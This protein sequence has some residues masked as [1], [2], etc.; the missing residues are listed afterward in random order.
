MA[1]YISMSVMNNSVSSIVLTG[2]SNQINRIENG[3]TYPG[4]CVYA[5]LFGSTLSQGMCNGL[6]DVLD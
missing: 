2:F 6:C 4:C 1:A 5:A 3:W